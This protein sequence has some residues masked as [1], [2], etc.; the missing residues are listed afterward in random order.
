MF[1][2]KLSQNVFFFDKTE[3]F[4]SW[5]ASKVRPLKILPG[6]FVYKENEYA[7]EMYFIIKGST[8]IMLYVKDTY[9][10][11]IELAEFYYFGEVDLLFSVSKVHLHT[12]Y[13]KDGCELFYLNSEDF[14]EMIRIF[15]EDSIKICVIA[16]ERLDRTA[17]KLK[18]AMVDYYASYDVQEYRSIPLRTS[19]NVEE[20]QRQTRGSIE[21]VEVFKDK[22]LYGQI[23]EEKDQ[24]SDV[25]TIKTKLINAKKATK[26][27][28]DLSSEVIHYLNTKR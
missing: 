11:V 26:L 25:Q 19:V 17:R 13:S 18:A 23:N 28:R 7:N 21:N 1:E 14:E 20:I 2:K 4:F 15:E 9:I 27:I 5:I 3:G 22:S 10:P 8:S 24:E 12:V 16:R 6:E